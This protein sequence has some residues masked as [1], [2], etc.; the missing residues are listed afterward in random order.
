MKKDENPKVLFEKLTAVQQAKNAI[1]YSC[2]ASTHC[3]KFSKVVLWGITAFSL[4]RE[5]QRLE[6]CI[7]KKC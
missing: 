6:A 1:L 4:A 3:Q 5:L 7:G 2:A